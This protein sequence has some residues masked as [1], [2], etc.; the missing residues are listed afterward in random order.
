MP[1]YRVC[2]PLDW[3]RNQ[4]FIYV[5]QT[6]NG[7]VFATGT[8]AIEPCTKLRAQWKKRAVD[9]VQKKQFLF[10][11][12][13]TQRRMLNL[14]QKLRH[15]NNKAYTYTFMYMLWT[16][17]KI[18]KYIRL[19]CVCAIFPFHYY[20]IVTHKMQRFSQC[21]IWFELCAPAKYGVYRYR[22][23]PTDDRQ[24]NM[25]ILFK[26]EPADTLLHTHS[27]SEHSQ[28]HLSSFTSLHSLSERS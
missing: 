24:T 13:R 26:N 4:I 19:L 7:N 8:Q 1:N 23:D 16:H 21:W 18:T 28:P 3:I 6:H 22:N 20:E 2:W 10:P 11:H 25:D 17:D 14:G 9:E 5:T 27:L 15:N 12:K